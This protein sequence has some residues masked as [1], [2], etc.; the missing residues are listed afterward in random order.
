MMMISRK[1]SVLIVLIAAAFAFMSS[2]SVAVSAGSK[3][4]VLSDRGGVPIEPYF[5]PFQDDHDDDEYENDTL[6]YEPSFRADQEISFSESQM[7][8]IK[9]ESMSAKLIL[10]QS[11]LDSLNSTLN[12]PSHI[13]PFFIV[14]FDQL[15]MAWLEQRL[16]FLVEMGA[17]GLVVNVYD[18]EELMH[19]RALAPGIELRPVHGELITERFGL[20][21]YPVLISG[22]GIEQ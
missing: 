12:I 8:P 15:S 4:K 10:D 14:G 21:I 16:S 7:L 18:V 22:A 9:T 5:A 19:L 11:E 13:T 6:I 17:V 3:L 20:S 2:S 1:L